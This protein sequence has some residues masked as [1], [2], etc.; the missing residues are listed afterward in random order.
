MN[1]LYIFDLKITEAIDRNLQFALLTAYSKK[2]D[3]IPKK[4]VY[5]Q[6]GKIATV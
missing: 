6:G 3:R 2:I 5:G 4:G 1:F